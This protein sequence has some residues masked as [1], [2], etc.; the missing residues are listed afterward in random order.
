VPRLRMWSE[1]T[2]PADSASAGAD[3]RTCSDA[4]TFAYVVIEPMLKPPSFGVM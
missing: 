2:E 1:P 4:A 3:A